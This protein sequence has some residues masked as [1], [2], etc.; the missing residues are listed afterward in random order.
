VVID[1]HQQG[2]VVAAQSRDKLYMML[3][4]HDW[5]FWLVCGT[6]PSVIT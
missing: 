2:E 1:Q 6:E 3:S 4:K 5:L